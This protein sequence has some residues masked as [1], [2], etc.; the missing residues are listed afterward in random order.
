MT[1]IWAYGEIDD[2]IQ[3]HFQNRGTYEAYLLDPD[4]TPRS[5]DP[6]YREAHPEIHDSPEMAVFRMSKSI[7]L[8]AQDT[9]Y[10]CSFHR[11]PT[12]T[13]HHIIGVRSLQFF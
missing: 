5:V 3:Y 4:L 12:I 11:V 2:D 7:S 6:E 10:W 1:L 8:P 13:K 9:V